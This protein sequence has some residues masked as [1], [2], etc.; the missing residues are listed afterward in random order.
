MYVPK[1]AI[2]TKSTTEILEILVGQMKSEYFQVY[3]SRQTFC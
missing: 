2:N 1:T 3:S